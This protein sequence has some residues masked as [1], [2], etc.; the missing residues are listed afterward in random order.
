MFLRGARQQDSLRI[1]GVLRAVGPVF[2]ADAHQGSPQLAR[3][4]IGAAAHVADAIRRRFNL[5]DGVAIPQQFLGCGDLP[6]PGGEKVRDLARDFPEGKTVCR[7][8][9]RVAEC[10]A[11]PRQVVVYPRVQRFP[12]PHHF[13]VV[14]GKVGVAFRVPRDVGDQTVDVK[15]RIVCAAGFVGKESCPKVAGRTGGFRGRERPAT[16]PDPCELF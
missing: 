16:V 15:V 5:R 1:Q 14:Q 3:V 13:P 8:L 9:D 6:R 12:H 2:R 11:T 4:Q 10:S 7:D